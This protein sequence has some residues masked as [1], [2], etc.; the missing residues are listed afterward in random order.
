MKI[1]SSWSSWVSAAAFGAVLFVPA[2]ADAQI[3][4]PSSRT[5][6]RVEQQRARDRVLEQRRE[7]D[8]VLAQQRARDRILGRSSVNDDSDSDSD[9]DSDGRRSC[10][11]F[12]KGEKG[13]KKQCKELRKEEKRFAKS[14]KR[15]AQRRQA[16]ERSNNQ[17]SFCR[18]EDG[19]L[20]DIILGRAGSST[21]DR[22]QSRRPGVHLPGGGF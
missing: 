1:K 21:A 8:Q 3:R 6:D 13:A 11:G 10:K 16:C 18:N 15:A 5:T 12:A 4:P 17:A 19:T 9:G 7:R 22:R 2:L 14:Q 20:S